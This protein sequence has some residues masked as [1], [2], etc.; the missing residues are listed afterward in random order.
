MNEYGVLV[1]I[2]GPPGAGKDTIV[3]LL[4]QISSFTKFPT[5]TTRQPRPEEIDGV[6]Y[7][8]V[9]REMFEHLR[10]MG[11]LLDHVIMGGNYYGLPIRNLEE[12]LEEGRDSVVI[13]SNVFALKDVIPHVITIFVLPPSWETALR[14]MRGRGMDD[15]HIA[16]RLRDDP[17]PLEL[18]RFYDLIVVNHDG[19]AQQTAERILKFVSQKRCSA[20]V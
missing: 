10:S 9:D 16:Q 19:E 18:L 3:K 15:Q 20:S 11:E 12:V 7:R 13:T 2:T 1:A 14:R 4:T 5:Y 8:F 6:H 17:T